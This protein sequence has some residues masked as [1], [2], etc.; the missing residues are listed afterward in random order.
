MI[1]WVQILLPHR[2]RS[3]YI[4]ELGVSESTATDHLPG[5]DLNLFGTSAQVFYVIVHEYSH[6]LDHWV[7]NGISTFPLVPFSGKSPSRFSS[8][9]MLIKL[10][11][12]TA[13]ERSRRTRHLRSYRV[14]EN[15]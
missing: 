4:S 3:S 1:G 8:L 7:G 14:C 13:M 12:H 9:I 11:S 2:R 6:H 5:N 15:K 10:Y